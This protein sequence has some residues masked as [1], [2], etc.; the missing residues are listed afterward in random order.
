MPN[1]TPS[2]IIQSNLIMMMLIYVIPALIALFLVKRDAE[3]SDTSRTIWSVV[4]LCFPIF[5][6]MGFV[7]SRM[8]DKVVKPRKI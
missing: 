6:P 7:V 1:T 8:M 2:S 5:G 3:L 4:V